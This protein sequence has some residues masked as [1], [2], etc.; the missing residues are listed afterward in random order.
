[1]NT[2]E[3]LLEFSFF[4][5]SNIFHFVGHALCTAVGKV[6]GVILNGAAEVSRTALEML[7]NHLD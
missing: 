4:I 5:M 6:V 3:I 7:A 1:M 2:D